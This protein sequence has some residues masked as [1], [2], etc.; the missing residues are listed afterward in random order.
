MRS[1]RGRNCRRDASNRTV[2]VAEVFSEI[3]ILKGLHCLVQLLLLL[4][5]LNITFSCDI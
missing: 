2:E 3:Q 1:F 4:V 5:N